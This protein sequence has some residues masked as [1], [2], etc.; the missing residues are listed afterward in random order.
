M[1]NHG[2]DVA[3]GQYVVLTN[4]ECFHKVDVLSGFDEEFAKHNGSVYVVCGCVSVDGYPENTPTF[5]SFKYRELQWFQ[6]TQHAP[7]DLCF[8]AAMAKSVFIHLGG[9][10]EEF[11]KGVGRADVE[12]TQRVRGNLN[13]VR[14][15]D[16]LVLHQN[17]PLSF[18]EARKDELVKNNYSCTTFKSRFK[19]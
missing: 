9:F 11:D 1:I 19:K 18:P 7:R 12:F 2:V 8:C 4:P 5:E 14:R 17:H 10:N 3:R 15:D 13:I 6:H 16:L